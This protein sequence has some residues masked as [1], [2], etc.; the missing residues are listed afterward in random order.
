MAQHEPYNVPAVISRSNARSVPISNASTVDQFNH[1]ELEY[2][3]LTCT[4]CLQTIKL[5]ANNKNEMSTTMPK[6]TWHNI[7]QIYGEA[8]NWRFMEALLSL[9][10]M[11]IRS[12]FLLLNGGIYCRK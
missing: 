11:N 7:K 3:R 2:V 1:I 5:P 12:L 8:G 9:L 6:N 10:L 4:D